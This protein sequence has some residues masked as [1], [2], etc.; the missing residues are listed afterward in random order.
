[1]NF[2]EQ[3]PLKNQY[4]SHLS[5]KN[6]EI[7]FFKNLISLGLSNNTKNIPKFRISF[8]FLCYLIFIEKIVQQEIAFSNDNSKQIQTKLRHPYSTHWELSEDT[9]HS[10]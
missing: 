5:S 7:K 9:K 6:Y 8:Q 2:Q 10:A 1:L 4:L 3:N